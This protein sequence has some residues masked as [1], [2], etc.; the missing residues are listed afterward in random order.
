M[1]KNSV[2]SFFLSLMLSLAA[3]PSNAQ[4]QEREP[5]LIVRPELYGAVAVEIGY[6]IT[7]NFQISGG[8]GLELDVTGEIGNYPTMLMGTRLYLSESTWSPIFDYHFCFLFIDG[9]GLP[10]HRLVLGVSWKK[11]DFGG[12]IIITK[13]SDE[14]LIGPC[15][16]LGYNF[17]LNREGR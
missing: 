5:G 16:T 15:I 1:N 8:F 14:T 11:L 4:T 10:N 9:W 3:L 13:P 6:Q 2:L 7:P 17:Q 12:G